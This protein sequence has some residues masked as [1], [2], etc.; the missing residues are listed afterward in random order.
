[1]D[2]QGRP[3]AVPDFGFLTTAGDPRLDAAIMNMDGPHAPAI[4]G[5]FTAQLADASSPPGTVTSTAS[6]PISQTAGKVPG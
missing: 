3:L 1:M 4:T 2:D 6:Q 5:A